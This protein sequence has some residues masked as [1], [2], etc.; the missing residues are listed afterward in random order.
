MADM[1]FAAELDRKG[2]NVEGIVARVIADPR[3]IPEL[4]DGL[5]APEGTLRYAYDKVLRGVAERRSEVVYPWFDVFVE[6]LDCG[7]SFLKWGAILTISHLAAADTEGKFEAIFDRYYTPIA[8]PA[9]ITGAN[10]VGSSARIGLAQPHL[11]DRVAAEIVKVEKAR[12]ERKG[13]PSPE[14][15]N[16]VIGHALDTFDTLFEDITDKPAI[17]AFVKRQRKNPRVPV[18][19]KAARF[20][21]CH[22]A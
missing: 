6:L 12:Y 14:C 4:V 9:M 2:A 20:L 15:R 21:A 3:P 7:N 8:G 16:V 13:Q 5:K 11:I 10:I 17:L 18:A 19:R 22:G 1:D